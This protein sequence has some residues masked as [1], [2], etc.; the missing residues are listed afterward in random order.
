[1]NKNLAD[2]T[3]SETTLL[4]DAIRLMDT[5]GRQILLAVNSDGIL[6][7]ILT[8]GDLRRHL[9]K[10]G[11]LDVPLT[12]AM[13]RQYVSLTVG[14]K[15]KAEGIIQQTF[16]NQIPIIDANGRVVDLMTVK[17]IAAHKNK[18]KN[19]PVVIMAGGRG[20]RLLPLTKIIP[21]PLIPV[22]DKTMCEAVMD[23]FLKFGFERFMLT[24]NYK[25]EMIKA[26]FAENSKYQI[27]FLEEPYFMGT[28]GSLALL[29]EYLT[30]TFVLSNCDSFADFDFEEMFSWHQEQQ[31]AMTLLG[32]RKVVNVPYGVVAVDGNNEVTELS[33]KPDYRFLISSGLYIMEPEM[34]D[35]IPSKSP[36]G[37]N[38]LIGRALLEHKKVVCYPIE[39][40]WYDAG[41]IEEYEKVIAALPEDLPDED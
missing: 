20:S 30:Q 4:R 8:D 2:L 17:D 27:E 10:D 24:L 11:R 7:G 16:C 35:L 12:A 40:G 25:K 9:L 21:K 39:K 26:Y 1:M 33:E 28:V 18:F 31:A 6:R 5:A 29:R 41:Q 14:E 36:F 34:I 13:N 32:L 23:L 37:M 38:E 15:H 3:V 22:G 19:H